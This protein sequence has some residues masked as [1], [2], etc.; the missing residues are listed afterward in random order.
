MT[1]SR[2]FISQHG[3]RELGFS[4]GCSR[5]GDSGARIPGA[6][7]REL[8]SL[9]VSVSIW[10]T[11]HS[12]R[13]LNVGIGLVK[14]RSDR[15]KYEDEIQKGDVIGGIFWFRMDRY[16]G[17]RI[18]SNGGLTWHNNFRFRH[19]NRLLGLYAKPGISKRI[20]LY[21][22]AVAN[23]TEPHILKKAAK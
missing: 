19:F 16:S 21:Q 3:G 14:T 15:N 2:V 8:T 12:R 22:A 7:L 11:P 10:K 20:H 6:I 18:Q 17:L 5:H 13:V 4:P 1:R 9:A 23:G